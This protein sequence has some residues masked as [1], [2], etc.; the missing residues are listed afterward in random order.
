MLGDT[1][2]SEQSTEGILMEGNTK[3]F[4]HNYKIFKV[5]SL[6]ASLTYNKVPFPCIKYFIFAISHMVLKD[7]LFIANCH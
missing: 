4:L 3:H 5:M 7:M 1:L 6:S 2:I